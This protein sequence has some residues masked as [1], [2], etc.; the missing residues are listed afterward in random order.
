MPL[1]PSHKPNYDLI[2]QVPTDELPWSLFCA[3]NMP[4]EEKINYSPKRGNNL[5]SG[6][7][8]PPELSE[9]MLWVPIVG[10]YLNIMVQAGGYAAPLEDCVD[11]IASDLAKG[12]QSE[13]VGK[14][15]GVKV[16]PKQQ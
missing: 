10:T 14:R 8:S 5:I 6:S 9:T 7:D 3:S 2:R 16:K 4:F 13:Y 1:F 11:F 12:L 15:V